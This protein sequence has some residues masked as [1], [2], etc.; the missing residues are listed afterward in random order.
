MRRTLTLA[1]LAATLAMPA[2]AND[3]LARSLGVAPG[4]YSTAELSLLRQ[5]RE[6][7]NT[8]L[9]RR[10]L[11]SADVAQVGF[12][13]DYSLGAERSA[14]PAA[15]VG[16]GHDQLARSLGMNGDDHTTAELSAMFLDKHN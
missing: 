1:A 3:Q 8:L 16:A 5:A 7:H 13:T 15:T 11:E 2:L 4:V 6:D 14:A 12:L 9:E 10:I